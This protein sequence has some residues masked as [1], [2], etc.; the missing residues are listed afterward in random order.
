MRMF[1]RAPRFHPTLPSL[2]SSLHHASERVARAASAV[3]PFVSRRRASRVADALIAAAVPLVLVLAMA[4]PLFNEEK[5]SR[6]Y[7]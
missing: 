2:S 4:S 5:R 7:W 1:G 6:H 3:A